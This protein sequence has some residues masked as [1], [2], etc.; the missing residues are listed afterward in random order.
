M[1]VVAG[2]HGRRGTTLHAHHRW[3][4]PT[5]TT[6]MVD[7]GKAEQLLTG[8]AERKARQGKAR[9]EHTRCD[10]HAGWCFRESTPADLC[11]RA[12]DEIRQALRRSRTP[13]T[14]DSEWELRLR[15]MQIPYRTHACLPCFLPAARPFTWISLAAHYCSVWPVMSRPERRTVFTKKAPQ[16]LACL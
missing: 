14:P 1:V 13:G 15:S 10:G 8:K 4:I 12:L 3:S 2:G 11:K 7:G 9:R 16:T 5:F 6:K